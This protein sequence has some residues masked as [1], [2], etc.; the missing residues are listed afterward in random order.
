MSISEPER[1][2]DELL[3]TLVRSGDARAGERLAARWHPRFLRTARRILGDD[4][5]AREAV[6]ETWAG[7]CRGWPR[8]SDPAMFPA[9]AFGILNRKCADALRRTVKERRRG[10][11]VPLKET[12]EPPRA[13]RRLALDAA[14]A[15]LSPDRRAAALLFFGEG[16]TLAEVAAALR[17]PIGTA[18][19]RIFHARRELKAH[20]EESEDD[21]V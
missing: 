12:P 21:T 3:V 19:S 7:V 16:L 13:Q 14:F 10:G 9:W 11:D 17:I 15:E 18:K 1:V 8:L 20:L 4:D 6:Q 5:L 2:L